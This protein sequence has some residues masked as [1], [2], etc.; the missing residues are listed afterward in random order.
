MR[1]ELSY[2]ELAPRD[3]PRPCSGQ[4]APPCQVVWTPDEGLFRKT[5]RRALVLHE[6]RCKPARSPERKHRLQDTTRMAAA[7][8]F[9]TPAKRAGSFFAGTSSTFPLGLR[10]RLPSPTDCRGP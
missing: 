5:T 7:S 10:A 8:F 2:Q 9:L 3:K 4:A 6:P 1:K